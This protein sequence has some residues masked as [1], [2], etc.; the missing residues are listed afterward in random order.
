MGIRDWVWRRLTAHGRARE[1]YEKGYSTYEVTLEILKPGYRRTLEDI[2]SVG[3][4]LDSEVKH[5]RVRTT[6]VTPRSDGGHK[7]VKTVSQKTTFYFVREGNHPPAPVERPTSSGTWQAGWYQTEHG[8][9]WWDGTLWTQPYN[10]P[11]EWAYSEANHEAGYSGFSNG[12]IVL[13][14]VLTMFTCGLWVPVWIRLA[15]KRRGGVAR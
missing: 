11:P 3:W 2:T 7:V 10:A 4:R 15:R 9:R 8:W 12:E 6:D 14:L 5:P 13:H 1:A